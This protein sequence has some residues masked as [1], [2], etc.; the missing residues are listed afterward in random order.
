MKKMLL[1]WL[2][3]MLLVFSPG[4][5]V[6]AA[7][8]EGWSS[9][10]FAQ[11]PVTCLTSDSNMLYAGLGNFGLWAWDGTSWSQLN[12][13]PT[14]PNSS[15]PISPPVFSLTTANGKLYAG[16]GGY[17]V[18]VWDGQSW[19]RVGG[20]SGLADSRVEITSLVNVNGTIYAG[21][22]LSGD[23]M[24]IESAMENG[25]LSGVWAW[26]GQS[27]SRV[28]SATD[29][30]GYLAGITCLTSSNGLLYAGTS[31]SGVWVWDGQAWSQVGD[32]TD[33]QGEH[34]ISSLTIAN[35]KL[36]A[37]TLGTG[38]W[39]W[40]GTSWS[41]VG[42]AADLT[43]PAANV[44]NLI[45]VNGTVYA[46]S[47]Y[48]VWAWNGSS[49]SEL[50]LKNNIAAIL[51]L[52]NFQGK[53]YA[54]TEG[55][56]GYGL[57]GLPMPTYND[58]AGHWAANNIEK[59]VAV[60]AVSGYPDGSFQPDSPI[61]RAEFTSMLVKAFKLE[62]K[63]GKVFTDTAEH[64]ARNAI[65]TAAAYGIVGGYDDNTFRPDDPITR[66]QMAVMTVKAARLSPASGEV[67]FTDSGEISAWAK[68][69]VVTAVQDG[70][71]NGYAD[72]TFEPQ[73]HA[74]RAEAVTVIVNGMK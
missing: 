2:V 45:T 6:Y 21:T 50:G 57:W 32:F 10:A 1:V 72:G 52:D 49:W 29:L 33:A 16:T 51:C 63:S 31:D 22:K 59:L 9:V 42:S 3:M 53:L 56:A 36:Y 48:G 23:V 15:P 65:A 26:D 73:G 17:G 28:G 55:L 4:L 18:W 70:I 58:I 43:G 8:E 7:D 67:A 38:V 54:G 71:M 24:T 62:F 14:Y 60:G 64:W 40:D 20:D 61:T 35:G 46:A 37:G 39:N 68:E 12:G 13:F 30:T 11:L 34:G 74:T 25:Y 19:S 69:S 44:D 41:Q 5:P 27:W 66:E 47:Y